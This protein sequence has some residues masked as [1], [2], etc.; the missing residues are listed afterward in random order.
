[1]NDDKKR[2]ENDSLTEVHEEISIEEEIKLTG[3]SS[4]HDDAGGEKSN[5]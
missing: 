5:C 1:M 2:K 4:V 3:I